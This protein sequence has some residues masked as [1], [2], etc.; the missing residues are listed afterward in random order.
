MKTDKY[1]TI[2]ARIIIQLHGASPIW[3]WS[4]ERPVKKLKME[5]VW[6]TFHKFAPVTVRME[7]MPVELWTLAMFTINV[8]SVQ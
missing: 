4:L 8:E 5:N 2:E 1:F 7:K 3:L 6:T